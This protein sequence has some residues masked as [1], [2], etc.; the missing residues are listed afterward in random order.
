MIMS[1]EEKRQKN[2]QF[3][4]DCREY[5][6]LNILSSL[7]SLTR[8][9]DSY[10]A[11]GG[12]TSKVGDF[13]PIH[14]GKKGDK[15]VLLPS[16]LEDG[17]GY[18]RKCGE[19]LS[20]MDIIMEDRGITQFAEA[21]KLVRDLIYPAGYQYGKSNSAPLEKPKPKITPVSNELTEREKQWAQKLR[22]QN[23][24]LWNSA[25]GI[26]HQVSK[27]LQNY[28]LSRAIL[29]WG[30]LGNNVRFHPAVQ[31]VEKVI[32]PNFLSSDEAQKE[33]LDKLEFLRN[34]RFYRSEWTNKDGDIFCDMGDHPAALF[35]MRDNHTLAATMIQRVYLSEDGKK[36]ELAGHHGIQVK[37]K[38]PRIPGV[39]ARASCHID[40]PSM[41]IIGVAE[42][43]ETTLAIRG[44]SRLPMNCCIDAAGL[45]NWEPTDNTKV[46]LIF[47]DKDAKGGGQKAAMKLQEKLKAQFIEAIIVTPPIELGEGDKSVDWQDCIQQLGLAALPNYVHQ[48]DTYFQ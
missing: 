36:M 17:A 16:A 48:W 40:P 26:N 41:P 31:F 12:K 42:G 23:N 25:Y 19:T 33:R 9:I 44:A 39:S 34:H 10:P 20:G 27:P 38:T 45:Q 35:I 32:N 4:E 18:C 37:K 43:P 15:F 7:T 28:F 47:E 8:A 21:A 2:Q 14:G 29:N 5:G 11:G 1:E 22:A 6:W 3:W 13:C 46:V 30:E 24:D